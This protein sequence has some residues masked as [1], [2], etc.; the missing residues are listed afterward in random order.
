MNC[1]PIDTEGPRFYVSTIEG[2]PISPSSSGAGGKRKPVLVA[3]VIDGFY[4]SEHGRF[5]SN[6][7]SSEGRARPGDSEWG[8]MCAC[9]MPKA[10][11]S[12]RCA[13]CR[14]RKGLWSNYR[15][16]ERMLAAAAERCAAL[17]AWHEREGWGEN[18]PLAS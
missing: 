14:R 12:R 4:G 1:A 11:H 6:E 9:G 5:A 2:Y 10:R 15:G 13:E 17:N 16:R 3:T 18:V 8:K 7:Q